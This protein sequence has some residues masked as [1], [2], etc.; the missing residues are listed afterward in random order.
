MDFSS[1]L[2]L[3]VHFSKQINDT[4]SMHLTSYKMDD[5]V[6]WKQTYSDTENYWSVW[7]KKNTSSRF[8]L[9]TITSDLKTLTNI[10]TSITVNHIGLTV[11]RFTT[12]YAIGAYHYWP[13]VEMNFNT[14]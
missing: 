9:K 2:T 11:V 12:T 1:H 6:F 13:V 8:W 7:N 4:C 14:Q 3:E 10:I 5:T